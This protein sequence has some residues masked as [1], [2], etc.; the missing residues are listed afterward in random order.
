MLRTIA[1]YPDPIE[2]HI[3]CGRL[4]AEGIEAQ[5]ADDQMNLANWEWR[6]ALGGTRILVLEDDAAR[7]RALI[8]EIDGGAFTLEDAPAPVAD[9]ET[10]SSRVAWVFAILFGIPLPWRRRRPA[11]NEDSVQV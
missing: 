9:H 7:A 6:Q 4:R 10:P 1:R 11:Q 2:A 3:V 8:A 5:V